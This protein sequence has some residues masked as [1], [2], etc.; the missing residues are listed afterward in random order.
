MK[1]LYKITCDLDL[2]QDSYAKNH[3]T[4]YPEKMSDQLL[5]AI[6]SNKESQAQLG[7]QD[8]PHCILNVTHCI[9]VN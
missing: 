2:S 5:R 1:K 7:C 3:E 4:A 6:I 8:G 9:H